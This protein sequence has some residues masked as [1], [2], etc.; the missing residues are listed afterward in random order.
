MQY[1]NIIA[2]SKFDPNRQNAYS[3]V[4]NYTGQYI[5][6]PRTMSLLSGSI[7]V[8]YL[9]FRKNQLNLYINYNSQVR[10][11]PITNGYYD[12]IAEFLP[13]LQQCTSAVL[14]NTFVWSYSQNTQSLKLSGANSIFQVM[15]SSYSPSDNIGSRLGF[16]DALNYNS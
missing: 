4:Q 2:S 8:N 6:V 9:S 1:N 12:D 11:I 7:P 3:W 14:P 5:S 10:T 16:I 13:V 15:G